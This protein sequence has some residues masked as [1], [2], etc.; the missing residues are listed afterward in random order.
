MRDIKFRAWDKDERKM[1]YEV[2]KT[3]D[4]TCRG[5]GVYEACFGDVLESDR[6]EVM[7]FT[8]LH[9]G[10]FKEVYE[11][12]IVT[13]LPRFK[14]RTYTGPIVFKGGAFVAEGFYFPHHDDPTD[15][16][17]AG[18]YVEVI[19]NIYENPELIGG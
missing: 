11:G 2:E 6:Y 1:I 9:D 7:Q 15:V 17:E 13:V 16:W 12:D 14:G 10:K 5:K 8:G 19:G 3:Y 18:E 4:D